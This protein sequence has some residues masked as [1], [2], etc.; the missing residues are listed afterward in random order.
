MT[1]GWNV[2][3]A[4]LIERIRELFPERRADSL[5]SK[6]DSDYPK[7]GA[8]TTKT[9]T[10][11]ARAQRGIQKKKRPKTKVTQDYCP[12]CHVFVVMTRLDGVTTIANHDAKK[13]GRCTRSGKPFK[14]MKPVKRDAMEFRVAGSFGTGKRQ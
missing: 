6:L 11:R 4:H 7:P 10:K 9:N 5:P 3:R 13:G 2:E 8:A 14:P 12:K 1:R